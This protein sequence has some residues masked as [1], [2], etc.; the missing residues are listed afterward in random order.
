MSQDL[1]NELK[2]YY[3]CVQGKNESERNCEKLDTETSTIKI[4]YQS[5]NEMKLPIGEKLRFIQTECL[6]EKISKIISI[7]KAKTANS[8]DIMAIEA[9]VRSVMDLKQS[10]TSLSQEKVKSASEDIAAK[11]AE[12]GVPPNV[13]EQIEREMKDMGG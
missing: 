9:S 10:Q 8:K 6:P 5:I 2:L 1:K 11:M 13:R 4:V 3:Q 7:M 12:K